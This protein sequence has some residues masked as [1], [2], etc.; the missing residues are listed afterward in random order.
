MK[1]GVISDTHLSGYDDRLTQILNQYF[2]D[3][4]LILHA[5]D[6]IVSEVL[7]V[8]GKKEV[9][10]VH[11]NMDVPSVKQDLPDR[12]ILELNGYR[13]GLIHGWGAPYDIE[14][15]LLQAM[16]PV[17]CLI[18]GHT[19]QAANEVKNGVLFFNPGSATDKRFA[20]RRTIGVLM[21]DKEMKSEII[22]LEDN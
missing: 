6:L 3:C 15:R 8:F 7:E 22:E 17:D 9:K 2:Y 16:G 11:G 5:G 10:A 4:D 21:I 12:M 18:Y 14:E 19:H 1:I 13:V 20:R